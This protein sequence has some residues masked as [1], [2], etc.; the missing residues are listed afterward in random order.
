[1][2][3]E[4]VLADAIDIN[5][6]VHGHDERLHEVLELGRHRGLFG[7]SKVVLRTQAWLERSA[8]AAAARYSVLTNHGVGL[9]DG[10][11]VERREC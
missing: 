5:A 8:R 2:L 1:V 4:R 11:V 9:Q 7:P 10:R 6:L 3:E